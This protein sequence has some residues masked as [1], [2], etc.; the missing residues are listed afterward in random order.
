M[1]LILASGSP[2]RRELLSA[3][4]VEF[5]IAAADI[6]E[7]WPP[8]ER[9][10]DH[11][12]RLA[13]EKAAAVSGK[14]PDELCLGADTIV[15][16]DG[17]VLGKPKNRADGARMLGLLSGRTHE[18]LTAVALARGGEIVE[19]FTGRA[20]VTFLPLDAAQRDWYLASDE[21]WDKAGGYAAQGKGAALIEKIEGDFHAVV[22]L[23]LAA[24]L[25]ALQ[26]R[27]VAVF[28]AGK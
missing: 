12:A 23:P 19:R 9:P 26:R 16:L 13:A 17:V 25:R 7:F 18:V 15:V 6:D 1:K 22:G 4:G 3:A 10:A 24:T 27:G 28:S 8:G 14:F 5:T 11:C 20:A 2:R 21:P